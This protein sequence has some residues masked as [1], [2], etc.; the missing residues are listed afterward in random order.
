MN[1]SRRS[2]RGSTKKGIIIGEEGEEG[3]IRVEAEGI[4]AEGKTKEIEETEEGTGAK[5]KIKVIVNIDPEDRK[6]GAGVS[7]KDLIGIIATKKN[8]SKNREERKTMI[9]NYAEKYLNSH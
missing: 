4:R 2:I 7:K 3:T 8:M 1:R 6:I 9:A 5:D